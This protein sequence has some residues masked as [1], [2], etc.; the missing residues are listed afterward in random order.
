MGL[1][2]F[3]SDIHIA[4]HRRSGGPVD[5]GVN[6]RCEIILSTLDAA[7]TVCKDWGARDVFILGDLFDSTS[8]GPRVIAR[9]QQVLS[10]HGGA[11]AIHVIP[12]NHDLVSTRV[13]DHALGPLRYFVHVVDEPA[14]FNV[15]DDDVRVA[16]VP[17]RPG[18]AA[19]DLPV[20]LDGLGARQDRT[21]RR[22]LGLH[23][24]VSHAGTPPYL[25]KGDGAHVSEKLLGSLLVDHDF[26]ACFSGHW[27]PGRTSSC[28]GRHIVQLGALCPRGWQ[29]LGVEGYGL[30]TFYDTASNTVEHVEVPGPR[31]LK[32]SGDGGLSEAIDLSATILPHVFV[33]WAVSS[34]DLQSAAEEARV[35]SRFHRVE[36]VPLAGEAQLSARAAAE[37]A[38]S[39]GDLDEALVDYI[40]RLTVPDGVDAEKVLERC[41]GYIGGAR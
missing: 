19:E 5:C 10:G 23:L 32:V 40:D 20:V 29:D 9:A 24:G 41:R 22:L 1:I 17:Y 30:V 13:G 34:A 28:G 4:N 21:T 31:F 16:L 33:E 11:L 27:H 15:G 7:L 36:V 3:F 25:I 37:A 6:E 35:S 12:G 14:I 26:D 8:P 38:R 2:A 18:S 39:A